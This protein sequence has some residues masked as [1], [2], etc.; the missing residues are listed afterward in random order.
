[1]MPQRTENT[2][3]LYNRETPNEPVYAFEG[4]ADNVKEFVWRWKGDPDNAENREFQLVTW[5]KDQNLRLWPIKP[6]V[7]RLVGHGKGDQQTHPTI[8]S[9]ALESNGVYRPHSFQRPPAQD[10]ESGSRMPA[11]ASLKV[12]GSNR[13][14]GISPLKPTLTGASNME[15]TPGREGTGNIYRDQKYAIPPLLWMQNVKTVRP[16]GEIRNDGT[17]EDVF[18]NV[19]EEMSIILNKFSS[20]GVRTERVST[21]TYACVSWLEHDFLKPMFQVNA[22]SRTCTI[23]LHGPWS[24]TGSA[25]LR[26][27]INFPP[28]YP[29]NTPP[30]FEIQ[31]NS[32]ISIFYRAHMAQDLNT[33]AAAYTA[34]KRYC[35]EPCLRY[36]LGET[37]SED[38]AHL[39]FGVGNAAGFSP[40][41]SKG[42]NGGAGGPN[43]HSGFGNWNTSPGV[44]NADSDDEMYVGSGFGVDADFGFQGKRVSMQSEKGIIVDMSVKQS[45][46]QNV[47]F[48]RLCGATFSGNG[49]C[50]C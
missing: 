29:D 40:F 30:E 42:A 44:N 22:A 5:S 28:Q 43:D 12:M 27:T 31:K 17:T 24:D 35:L 46:D 21:S 34:Q 16:T 37:P 11:T 7:M 23:T 38:L 48:P 33:L 4:H 41:A 32:M 45:A 1:M 39:R 47:P 36:L 25:F 49:E 18:Q 2:L 6:E 14:S 3:F 9:K 15:T 50:I 26:I 13:T 10:I 8:A 20:A 19:A